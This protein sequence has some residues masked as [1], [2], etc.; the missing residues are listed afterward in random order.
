MGKCSQTC[1]PTKKIH[2]KGRIK[3]SM[4][5][6]A[7]NTD[8]GQSPAFGQGWSGFLAPK[9]RAETR[10]AGMPI[11]SNFFCKKSAR[12]AEILRAVFSFEKFSVCAPI[13]SF[14]SGFSRSRF[15]SFCKSIAM[16]AESGWT[17]VAES[18]RMFSSC[19]T[20]PS[21][22]FFSNNHW[23]SESRFFMDDPGATCWLSVD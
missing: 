3:I 8:G 7:I 10:S 2:C 18:K 23:V 14:K 9:P 5:R 17:A 22:V 12:A 21:T 19:K 20:C 6:F 4:R 1:Q 16:V 13:S 11:S 15:F